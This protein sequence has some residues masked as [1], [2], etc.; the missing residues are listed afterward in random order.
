MLEG[1]SEDEVEYVRGLCEASAH[2]RQFP[3]APDPI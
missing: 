2:K 1:V 3:P